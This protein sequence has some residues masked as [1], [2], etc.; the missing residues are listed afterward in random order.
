MHVSVRGHT[1]SVHEVILDI[2]PLQVHAAELTE[3]AT[4]YGEKIC[5]CVHVC[6]FSCFAAEQKG[7]CG[8]LTGALWELRSLRKGVERWDEPLNF[9]LEREAAWRKNRQEEEKM[10]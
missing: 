10:V 9:D 8:F 5:V 4:S 7:L 1:S 3:D 2:E 6:V